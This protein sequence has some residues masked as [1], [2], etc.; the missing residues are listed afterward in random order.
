MGHRSVLSSLPYSGRTKRNHAAVHT[1]IT[2]ELIHL[3][4]SR[5][6]LHVRHHI[7][8]HLPCRFLVGCAL[9]VL[10]TDTHQVALLQDAFASKCC[11]S[12]HTVQVRVE[13]RVH[14]AF[15]HICY[16]YSTPID[17]HTS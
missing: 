1:S 4:A 11:L 5:T 15:D 14:V 7:I 16:A 2:H 12:C 10:V 13:Q 3:L 9:N 8:E 17:Y 6:A